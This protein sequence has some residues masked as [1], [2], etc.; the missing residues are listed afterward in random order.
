MRKLILLFSLLLFISQV[1][2]QVLRSSGNYVAP[3]VAT[4]DTLGSE[5]IINGGF[6]NSDNW[7]VAGDV[8]ITGGSASFTLNDGGYILQTAANIGITLELNHTYRMEFDIVSA[9][10]VSFA[11][12]NGVP[13]YDH[14][15]ISSYSNGHN[16][17]RF[18]TS[19][20]WIGNAG[21]SVVG[22]GSSIAFTIDNISLKEV[23]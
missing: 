10:A 13:N 12:K 6:A 7:A 15:A 20:S 2:G 18:H 8:T 19:D 1:N 9:G 23:L 14:V 3:V 21:I 5:M 22:S 17:V 11:I 16:F 4:A